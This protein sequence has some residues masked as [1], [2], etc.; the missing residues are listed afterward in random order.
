[1]NKIACLCILS[2]SIF[3]ISSCSDEEGV[4]STS[5]ISMNPQSIYSV[6]EITNSPDGVYIFQTLTGQTSIQVTAGEFEYTSQSW[7]QSQVS[8]VTLFYSLYLNFSPAYNS[9]TGTQELGCADIIIKTFQNANLINT[10]NFQI[11]YSQQYPDVIYC[12]N[13]VANNLF[14]KNLT[15][16]AD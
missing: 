4:I 13:L 8:G 14:T 3:S 11:G 2:V 1:M 6:L 16:V 10:E 7:E 9:T 15:L 12:D 5:E